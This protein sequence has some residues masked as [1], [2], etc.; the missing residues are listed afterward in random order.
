MPE[1]ADIQA[2][3][4]AG[5]VDALRRL[6]KHGDDT[7][8]PEAAATPPSTAAKL[9]AASPPTTDYDLFAD[10]PMLR[11][12]IESVNLRLRSVRTMGKLL[13]PAGHAVAQMLARLPPPP[14]PAALLEL[15]AGAGVPS[16][17][18]AASGAFARGVLAT[19]CFEENLQLIR[20]N[21]TL[22]GARLTATARLDVGEKGA[23]QA[24]VAQHLCGGVDAP[25]L[26]VACD[27]ACPP[28][29]CVA[30]ENNAAWSAR[31]RHRRA[32][33]R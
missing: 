3:L 10:R 4:A 19:D 7:P 23:L 2:L 27:S 12:S 22:N 5:D 30:H 16:L 15:G 29:P 26:L 25:L 6:L 11:L 24:L 18:A 32:A 13:W 9:P 8:P 31:A 1:P 33:P 20:H 28:R 21:D 17:I 14:T